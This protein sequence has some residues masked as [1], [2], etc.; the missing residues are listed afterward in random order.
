MK[1]IGIDKKT[2]NKIISIYEN[3]KSENEILI[4]IRKIIKMKLKMMILSIY[5][6]IN[7]S[8][9]EMKKCKK[10]ILNMNVMI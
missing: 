6:K 5:V 4:K 9:K 1:P 7:L 2:G 8:K 10:I 3:K